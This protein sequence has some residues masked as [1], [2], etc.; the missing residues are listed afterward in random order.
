MTAILQPDPNLSP[1]GL[2][3]PKARPLFRWAGGKRRFILGN[4]DKFPSFE[5]TYHEP[6]AGSLAVYFGWRLE[7]LFL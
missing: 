2:W 5:G 3:A 6:F 7:A 1:W 4:S